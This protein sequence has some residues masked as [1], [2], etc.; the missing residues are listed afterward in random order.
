MDERQ[1]DCFFAIIVHRRRVIP[2]PRWFHKILKM[3]IQ[4]LVDHQMGVNV[5]WQREL[6]I[7]LL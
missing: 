1:L 6:H 5:S 2:E 3:V 7:D 4:Q